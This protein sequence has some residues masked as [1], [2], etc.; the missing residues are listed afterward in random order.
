MQGLAN[1]GPNSS[2]NEYGL[3]GLRQRNQQFQIKDRLLIGSQVMIT[4]NGSRRKDLGILRTQAINSCD[5]NNCNYYFT[6][7]LIIVSSITVLLETDSETMTECQHL[8]KFAV[9]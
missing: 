9:Y 3:P 7:I 8:A 5:R 4:L 1:A 2:T 6:A